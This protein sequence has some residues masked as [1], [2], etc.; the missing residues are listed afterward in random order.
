[1][2]IGFILVSKIIDMTIIIILKKSLLEDLDN[3]VKITKISFK[4]CPQINELKIY[5]TEKLF[6]LMKMKKAMKILE[7]F[8]KEK[9]DLSSICKMF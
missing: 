8:Y 5:Q 3:Q 2:I 1:M 7:T 9:K 4:K 6:K